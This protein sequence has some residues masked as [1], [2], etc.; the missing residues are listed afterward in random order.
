MQNWPKTILPLLATRTQQPRQ[1]RNKTPCGNP[2]QGGP[3]D[4]LDTKTQTGT[5][6]KPKKHKYI[7]SKVL[8]DLPIG[9]AKLN[10]LQ[11]HLRLQMPISTFH[12][13]HSVPTF[14]PDGEPATVHVNNHNY[15]T[16]SSTWTMSIHCLTTIYFYERPVLLVC[17]MVPSSHIQV[18]WWLQ[19][20][21][22]W[23][24][25]TLHW[26]ENVFTFAREVVER[27]IPPTV[28]VKEDWWK[29][30]DS[31]IGMEAD[32]AASLLRLNHSDSEV[33]SATP[34]TINERL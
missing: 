30:Q 18:M 6:S 12:V 5:F 24:S 21:A 4:L 9:I 7:R 29:L 15:N 17:M 20:L 1:L 11:T 25:N 10:Y 14:F 13:E 34:E 23:F 26:D 3:R 32:T 28:L 22:R 27:M 8:L 19:R 33:M 16:T 31:H 2:P